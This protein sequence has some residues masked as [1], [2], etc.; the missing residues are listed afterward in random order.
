MEAEIDTYDS[1]AVPDI[2]LKDGLDLDK[3]KLGEGQVFEVVKDD[4]DDDEQNGK[5][6]LNCKQLLH[7]IV[8]VVQFTDS[9]SCH[10]YMQHFNSHCLCNLS[11]DIASLVIFSPFVPNLYMSDGYCNKKLSYCWETVQRESMP[12][13]AEMDEEITT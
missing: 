7:R 11:L 12:R 4:D 3:L 8:N 10:R 2:R 9:I 6:V 13:I 1:E 5:I